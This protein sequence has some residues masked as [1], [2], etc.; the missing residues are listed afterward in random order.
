MPTTEQL[1]I[2]DPLHILQEVYKLE[3][4]V[5]GT[6]F[7]LLCPFHDDT[8]PSC[9]VNL[10]TGFYKCFS[11]GAKGDII[12]L[13]VKLL[14]RSRAQV[15]EVIK[16]NSLEGRAA[17]VQR[18]VMAYR[19][20]GTPTREKEGPYPENLH[21]PSQYQDGPLTYMRS[22]GFYQ[23]TCEKWGVRFVHYTH[24]KTPDKETEGFDIKDSIAI[25]I[26]DNRSTLRGWVYRATP[27]SFDW[28]P[29]YLLTPHVQL[30]SIWF[31]LNLYCHKKSIVIVEGPLDAMWLSQAGIPAIAM[32]GSQVTEHKINKLLGFKE[33]IIMA[34]YDAAGRQA[35]RQIGDLT[36]GIVPTKVALWPRKLVKEAQKNGKKSLDPQ[37]IRSEAILRKMVSQAIPYVSWQLRSR[38]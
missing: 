1:G 30:D 15:E 20:N 38:P 37:D 18:K 31:G 26:R 12:S 25:P 33:L 24:I 17:V 34:D 36:K 23:G 6:W 3:G 7:D 28:Q 19:H 21:H 8:H 13:G 27:S 4:N 10:N 2:A 11:C 16:P 14:K 5:R 35:T 9:G 22:R 29:K 32:L